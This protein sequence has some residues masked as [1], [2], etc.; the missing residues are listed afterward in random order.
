MKKD[1]PAVWQKVKA[2]LGD[3]ELY[4]EAVAK[5]ADDF[6]TSYPNL[7]HSVH[8]PVLGTVPMASEPACIADS[9]QTICAD[10]AIVQYSAILHD[11]SGHTSAERLEA[12]KFVLHLVG[13]LHQSLHGTEP[14]AQIKVIIP[15][16]ILN[17]DA[18]GN[19][20]A[21][22]IHSIWDYAIVKRHLGKDGTADTLG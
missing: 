17:V 19:A 6:R 20:I 15:G 21:S 4:D 9:P 3:G 12:L 7:A 8:I 22:D 14:G 5:R 18:A 10:K 13:D 16:G 1:N 11:A 2:L